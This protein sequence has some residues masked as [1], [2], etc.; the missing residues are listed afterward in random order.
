MQVRKHSWGGSA[1]SAQLDKDT[2]Q[3]TKA[4]GTEQAETGT[5]WRP[6]ESD[7]DPFE[8]EQAWESRGGRGHLR[9]QA[10]G[11]L[12]TLRRENRTGLGG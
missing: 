9:T 11:S 3:V 1:V 2:S 12:M 4:S 10:L 5:V 6:G 7:G 8:T